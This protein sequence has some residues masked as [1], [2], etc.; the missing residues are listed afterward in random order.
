M[1]CRDV[2]PP[3]S[4]HGSKGARSRYDWH[5]GLRVSR[6]LE[7]EAAGC[8][9]GGDGETRGEAGGD[10]EVHREAGG[11]GEGCAEAAGMRCKEAKGDSEWYGE[12]A[13]GDGEGC[14]EAAG[15]QLRVREIIEV[16]RDWVLF[17]RKRPKVPRTR[18]KVQQPST[19]SL[20]R[21]QEFSTQ[22]QC[23]SLTHM[24]TFIEFRVNIE[25][26]KKATVCRPTIQIKFQFHHY[27]LYNKIF[28]TRQYLTIFR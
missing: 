12:E 9:M 19:P 18:T 28:K 21:M 11:D 15:H 5:V 4:R 10:G 2:P 6:W 7:P 1:P 3:R 14:P 17:R 13:S 25:S 26:N 24:H 22:V 23:C 27:I 20:T 8:S 16:A